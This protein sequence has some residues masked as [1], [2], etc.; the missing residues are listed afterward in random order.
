MSIGHLIKYALSL[1][2][3]AAVRGGWRYLKRSVS[4]SLET[5]WQSTD[6]TYLPAETTTKPNRLI[7]DLTPLKDT[8]VLLKEISDMILDHRFNLLGSGLI[9]NCYGMEARGFGSHKY[10]AHSASADPES[11]VARLN[12]GNRQ[13]ALS[14][15]KLIS[16][17]YTPIDWHLDF[18]SG[19]RWPENV[20]S[21]SIR[22]GHKAGVDI[23]VPWELARFQHLPVL[24]L[25]ELS[26]DDDKTRREF[27]NQVLDFISANPPGWG[28]NWACT[29]DVAIRAANMVLAFD[30]FRIS[31]KPYE[32]SFQGEFVASIR[33]HGRHIVRNLEW[34]AAKRGNHY[35]ANISGLAFIAT[36][37][38][39]DDEINSW[40]AFA[41]QELIT[42][43]EFQFLEDGANFEGS[44]SYHSL[45]A[46][47]VAYATALFLGLP[48]H[49]RSAMQS[50]S[51][52]AW[53]HQ[54]ELRFPD[55]DWH[56]D[57]GP[58]TEQHFSRLQKM[59][60]FSI[61]V[62]KPDG[63]AVQVGDNDSG[64]FFEFGS[65]AANDSRKHPSLDHRS[66][67]AAINGLIGR[68]DFS[69]F[70][71]PDHIMEFGIVR[72]LSDWQSSSDICRPVKS[73]STEITPNNSVASQL[74]QVDIILPDS[75]IIS[76]MKTLS[77]PDFGLFI[78]RSD[79]LFLSV[80][81]GP[82][83]QN[84]RGGHAH[85]DQLAIELQIDG[86]DWI[87]DPGSYVY[88]A[89][90]KLR[91]AYRSAF[92]HSVP[93]YGI[94]EPSSL[95]LGMF[96][97]ENNAHARTLHFSDAGFHGVHTAY[98]QPV[99][100]L[101]KFHD[102]MIT[103]LDG[104][105]GETPGTGIPKVKTARSGKELRNIFGLTLPFSGGYGLLD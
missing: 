90:P 26:S 18:K 13:R 58:F 84:G 47:M 51:P 36:F 101:I 9:E 46:E 16:A 83:G 91:D 29:M 5:S 38:P 11:L 14:I 89:D 77:Y 64:R 66:V 104:F 94:R 82:V 105:G 55:Y 22:Y 56:T 37:L 48:A 67:V 98:D 70:T 1:S 54:P 4:G 100:R 68:E 87:A 65:I 44:T 15:R 34:D 6:C 52:L 33:A 93:R 96:R 43:T 39:G 72:S 49:R 24:A 32:A 85:N 3:Q 69:G 25:N 40:L 45:S 27:E 61:S 60:E 57:F 75:S 62:T 86:E 78:W 63:H 73:A 21:N 31:G 8:G 50:V 74:T 35:L 92:A 28:V 41:L 95:G 19:Y 102:G 12:I 30:L 80:R 23:K 7:S 103:L 17:D 81:C 42:E 71:G 59:A 97:L 2:P 53:P 99:F 76:D 10:P 88:T 20:A 79:R